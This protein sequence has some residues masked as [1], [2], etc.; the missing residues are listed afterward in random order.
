MPGR[1]SC[2]M[3]AIVAMTLSVVSVPVSRADPGNSRTDGREHL[4]A[5][6]N[7]NKRTRT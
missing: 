4:V 3:M 7:H 2:D 6:T 5:T 1:G